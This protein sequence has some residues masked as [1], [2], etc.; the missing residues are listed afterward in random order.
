MNH[1][2]CPLCSIGQYNDPFALKRSITNVLIKKIKCPTCGDVCLGLQALATHISS[3][4]LDIIPGCLSKQKVE[5]IKY[6]SRS[7]SNELVKDFERHCQIIENFKAR[8]KEINQVEIKNDLA[9]SIQADYL[10]KCQYLLP[11]N[12]DEDFLKLQAELH[13]ENVVDK[14]RLSEYSSKNPLLLYTEIEEIEESQKYSLPTSTNDFMPPQQPD[15]SKV[16]EFPHYGDKILPISFNNQANPGHPLDKPMSDCLANISPYPNQS[17]ETNRL[18]IAKPQSEGLNKI[19]N[20]PQDFGKQFKSKPERLNSNGNTISDQ[21]TALHPLPYGLQTTASASQGSNFFDNKSNHKMLM[22]EHN[23]TFQERST[24]TNYSSLADRHINLDASRVPISKGLRNLQTPLSIEKHTNLQGSDPNFPENK[25]CLRFSTVEIPEKAYTN[26]KRDE[27]TTSEQKCNECRVKFENPEVLLIHKALCHTKGTKC[28]ICKWHCNT[29]EE[30]LGHFER[31]HPEK[32]HICVRCGNAY[33]TRGSLIVHLKVIHQVK[34]HTSSDILSSKDVRSHGQIKPW[35]CDSC[36]KKFTTKYFL[37]K[38]K[39]LHTGEAP[40]KC[41]QCERSFTFQ[42]SFHK[43]LLYHTNE[44]PHVCT[45]CGRAF[46]EISTLH[47]H[48]RIHTGEKPF[49]CETCG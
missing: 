29:N 18:T 24:N 33:K 23:T 35:E 3:H 4:T 46:R 48:E 27:S 37:K 14:N 42:Q 40:F 7:E 22:T 49:A 21:F 31:E 19:V 39:R 30:L 36:H 2:I 13:F 10:K 45:H 8:E 28:K 44:K 20:A 25:N 38:H 6:N 15:I 26:H 41:T 1:L 47:N 43:H 16:S 9:Y 32:K 5:S 12:D 17:F 34:E 11:I